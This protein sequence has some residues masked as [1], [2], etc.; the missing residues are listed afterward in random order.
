MTR[1]FSPPPPSDALSPP[2][3]DCV[4]AKGHL[5]PF[6]R[7]SKAPGVIRSRLK[8]GQLSAVSVSP[9]GF[10]QWAELENGC[11]KD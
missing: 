3:W 1:E 6:L 2:R 8:R 5:E 9:L 7:R 4:R 10:S 11:K